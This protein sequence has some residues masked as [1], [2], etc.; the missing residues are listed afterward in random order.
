MKNLLQVLIF[1]ISLSKCYSQNDLSVY[2]LPKDKYI[3]DSIS[4]KTKTKNFKLIVLENSKV[5]N[6]QNSQH[7]S[8]IIILLCNYNNKLY[9]NKQSNEL[10]F[11]Y[12]DNCPADGYGRAVSKNNYF[13]IEQ[14][15]CVDFLFVNSYITFKIDEN[16]NL[17]TLHKYGEEYTDR[18][19]PNKKI[20]SKVWTKKD[21]GEVKFES[22]DE[23]FL[24][25]LTQNN[26]KKL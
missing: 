4:I 2:K 15:S 16:T 1:I 8:N 23:N 22:L 9:I 20:P 17:I 6:K 12:D 13:T 7:N 10:I 11:S 21:F 14:S 3:L 24:L 25:K 26:P 19:N 5:K 18:S